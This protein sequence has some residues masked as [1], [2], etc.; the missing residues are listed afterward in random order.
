MLTDGP[1]VKLRRGPAYKAR[2]P[3]PGAD[4]Y[5]R[6]ER[7]AEQLLQ[8]AQATATRKRRGHTLQLGC[9]VYLEELKR[10]ATLS[11][12]ANASRIHGVLVWDCLPLH[13]YSLN[14]DH[15]A[16][17]RNR[18]V[19]YVTGDVDTYPECPAT[20]T[21]S[22]TDPGVDLEDFALI[23]DIELT[24]SLAL[25]TRAYAFNSRIE[26]SRIERCIE[27]P[28][29]LVPEGLAPPKYVRSYNVRRT[30]AMLSVYHGIAGCVDNISGGCNGYNGTK[31]CACNR[32][33]DRSNILKY[34][35]LPLA[36]TKAPKTVSLDPEFYECY[37]SDPKFMLGFTVPRDT[38]RPQIDARVCGFKVFVGVTVR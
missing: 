11:D 9:A 2:L 37:D 10:L 22:H 36:K 8:R 29:G 18:Q 1:R 12:R 4:D 24:P 33:Y 20:S 14:H 32:A 28:D 17:M 15:G 31:D 5:E 30:H 16:C 7:A 19:N 13:G 35:Y 21:D 23:V 6:Y 3:D 38:P 25:L 27:S 26:D 34:A